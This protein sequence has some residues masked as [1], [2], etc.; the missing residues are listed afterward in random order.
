MSVTILI[1][2]RHASNDYV[3]EG[4]LAGWTPGV[5]LNAQGQ[6]E[7][8]AVA[9]RLNDSAIQAIYSSPLERAQET[10]QA[11]AQCQK[12]PVQVRHDLGELAMGEWT[13]KLV[14]ELES[15]DLWKEVQ[16]N[17][18]QTTLP[19]GRGIC[20][21]AAAHRERPGRHCGPTSESGRCR[22]IARRSAQGGHCA[23]SGDGSQSL[24]TGCGQPCFRHGFRLSRY[25]SGAALPERQRQVTA[26]QDRA[27]ET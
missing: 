21:Y 25:E 4:R 16:N 24:S 2:I 8:D 26:F 13:G 6:R 20:R 14:R 11:I 12:L 23:L 10:A 5:H 18:A 15:L 27:R 9:R 22:R 17:P 3:R 19:G 1:L 7:A